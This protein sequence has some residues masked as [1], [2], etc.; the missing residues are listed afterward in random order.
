[1]P[2]V[3]LFHQSSTLEDIH[4]SGFL[5]VGF[6][7]KLVAWLKDLDPNQMYPWRQLEM[8]FNEASFRAGPHSEV[9]V[10]MSTHS[11]F[12][13]LKVFC[14]RDVLSREQISPCLISQIWQR[15]EAGIQYVLERVCPSLHC[16]A[17]VSPCRNSLANFHE[18]HDRKGL[19]P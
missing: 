6:F 11:Y 10:N 18:N 13:V 14:I 12:I 15:F 8:S 4:S 16:S 2:I 7:F 9:L 19:K 3:Y 1:M 17:C 5:P